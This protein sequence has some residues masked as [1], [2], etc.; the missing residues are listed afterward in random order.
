MSWCEFINFK[1]LDIYNDK[2]NNYALENGFK[3]TNH[4]RR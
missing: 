2:I 3:G 1:L 4:R